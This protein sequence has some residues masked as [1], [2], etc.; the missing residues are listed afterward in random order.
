MDVV[1]HHKDRAF[2]AAK[3]AACAGKCKT[4]ERY[5]WALCADFLRA[6]GLN[7]FQC[8]LVPIRW[9]RRYLRLGVGIS[10]F[11][12]LEAQWKHCPLCIRLWERK[13]A[14]APCNR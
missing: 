1:G 3:P 11:H 10:F 6:C 7:D 9:C 4:R 13:A 14:A 8:A 12:L 5:I 2:T